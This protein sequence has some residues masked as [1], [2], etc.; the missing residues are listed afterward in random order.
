MI[1][2]AWR[3]DALYTGPYVEHAPDIILELALENGYSHSCLR[4]RGGEAFRRLAPEEFVGG[5]EKGMN[6]NHRAE[7]VFL[8]SKAFDARAMSLLDIAPTVYDI[9]G[10]AA[11]EMD[12]R[13]MLGGPIEDGV[14]PAAVVAGF[15]YTPEQEAEVEARL[16]ALG[17]FE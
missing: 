16:R 6:G 2:K 10:V 12:G 14:M 7:G 8:L 13:S 1:R 9:L 5:K 15:D 3:R 11:P 4:S 17:Y